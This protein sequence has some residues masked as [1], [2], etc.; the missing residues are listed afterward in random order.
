MSDHDTRCDYCDGCTDIPCDCE[1]GYIG[2]EAGHIALYEY[3]DVDSLWV[4][5]MESAAHVLWCETWAVFEESRGESFSEMDISTCAPRVPDVAEAY[6]ADLLDDIETLN[7]CSV[8]ELFAK[9][10]MAEGTHYED[11]TAER[12]GECLAYQ[13]MGCGVT[14]EGS[15]PR[16]GLKVPAT[17]E[18]VAPYDLGLDDDDDDGR[19]A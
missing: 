9:A 7:R 3:F 4:E 18:D 16:I 11:R 13:S 6:A 12:F 2:V 5:I 19:T 10:I 8:A 15:H 17:L 1:G 14:W